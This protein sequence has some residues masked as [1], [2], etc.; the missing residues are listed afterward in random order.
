M[1]TRMRTQGSPYICGEV[2]KGEQRGRLLGFPTAN[3]DF[4]ASWLSFGVYGVKVRLQD[5]CYQGIMNIGVKPTFHE[6]AFPVI[7]VH[8]LDFSEMIYGETLETEILFKVRD[9]RKFDSFEDLK[10]QIK[11]DI[12][13]TKEKF[14]QMLNR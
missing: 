9:E 6:N 4:K 13:F 3:I 14:R 2:V 5:Q 8:I 11:R 12:E 7:E 10:A 1:L